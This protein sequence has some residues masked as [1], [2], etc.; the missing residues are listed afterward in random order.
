MNTTFPIKHI[1]QLR[2]I[3][4]G[5]RKENGLTQKEI[6]QRLGVSQ[7]AYARLESNPASSSFERLFRVLSVLGVELTLSSIQ[8]SAPTTEVIK[9]YE[10]SPAKWEKW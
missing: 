5:F 2:P 3:L 1:N 7:Q 9:K 4:I 8:H 6:S 10:N